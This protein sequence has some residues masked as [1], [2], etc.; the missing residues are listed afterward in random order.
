M[1]IEA[2][3]QQ[4]DVRTLTNTWEKRSMALEDSA[5][6]KIET[7]QNVVAETEHQNESL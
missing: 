7:L 5:R 1:T 4:S 6:R 2:Q 3:Q